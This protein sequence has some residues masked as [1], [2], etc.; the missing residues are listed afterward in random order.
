MAVNITFEAGDKL[1]LKK[2]HPCGG[3][4]WSVVKTGADIKI[5][6]ETCG[7]FLNLS[8]DDLKKRVKSKQE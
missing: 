2:A 6:C 7:K 4:L 1:L 8:R 3:A 5:R